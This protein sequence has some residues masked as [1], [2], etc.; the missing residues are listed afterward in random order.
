MRDALYILTL[1][2]VSLFVPPMAV[3]LA[4]EVVHQFVKR[5]R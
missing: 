3:V 4:A 2:V 5:R 1:T